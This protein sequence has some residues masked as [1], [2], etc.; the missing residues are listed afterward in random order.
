MLARIRGDIGLL[1]MSRAIPLS[2]R[3]LGEFGLIK[4]INRLIKPSSG[5]IKGIGDDAAVLSFPLN[6]S[7]YLLLTTDMLVEGVHFL[8]SSP[9]QDIGHK[10]MACNISDIAAMGGKP[11]YAVVSLGIPAKRSVDDVKKI[12]QGMNEIAQQFGVA[13]VGGDTVKSLN[14]VI[15]VALTGE[16]KRKDVVFRSGAQPGD[17][18]FVSGRL[19]NSFLSGRHLKFTP[20]LNESQYLV[21]NFK[22]HAMIDISDGLLADLQHILQASQVGAKIFAEK[23]PLN[24][25]ARLENALSDGEDFE[26]LFTLSSLKAKQLRQLKRTK[27]HDFHFYPIGEIVDQK[28]GLVVL[29]PN[30]QAITLKK[31]GY[32]H[33]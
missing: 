12:Y 32:T 10:A 21:K 33:F 18:I 16:V 29:K 15:N 8:K 28:K 13:I 17:V 5:V 30:G 22:P 26:L 25:K 3:Q 4:E 27:S 19:G 31:K 1:L 2:L 23:I 24:A 14:L 6:N 11:L 20:R 9:P 7:T